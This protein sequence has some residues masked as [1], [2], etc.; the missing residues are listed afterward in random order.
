MQIKQLEYF[1]EV[2]QSASINQTAQKLF[3]SQ[4]ALSASLTSL[5]KELGYPLLIRS[6]QGVSLTEKGQLVL[7]EAVTVL[8]TVH[9]WYSISDTKECT[10]TGTVHVAA[11]TAICNSIMP[12]IILECKKS[13]PGI[14][15]Q[16]YEVRGQALF[17]HINDEHN[18]LIIN[19]YSRKT[20]PNVASD[21]NSHG[22]SFDFL[23]EDQMHVYINSQ[24]PLAKNKNLKLKDLKEFTL[25]AYPETFIF[26]YQ[27]LYGKFNHQQPYRSTHQE[28]LFNLILKDS[29][30]A[31]VQP[32]LVSR[33][34]HYIHSGFVVDMTLSGAQLPFFFYMFHSSQPTDAANA[35]IQFLKQ[36]LPV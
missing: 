17:D 12:D 2:A 32:G 26:P 16:L 34:N 8:E 21:A 27:D 22:L 35:F 36:N 25:A 6:K 1:L 19:G 13:Y 14:T 15:I 18:F 30:I 9:G 7:K 4:Q 29:S 24:H 31:T 11:P 33:N 20:R 3:I 28:N 5:E 23:L 10:V